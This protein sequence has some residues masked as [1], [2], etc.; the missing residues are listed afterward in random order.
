MIYTVKPL[1]LECT[2]VCN[3]LW[4]VSERKWGFPGDSMVKNPPAKAGDTGL[5]PDLAD[6][7]MPRNS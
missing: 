7:H 3:W 4:N 5:I 1:E 6:S 2:D